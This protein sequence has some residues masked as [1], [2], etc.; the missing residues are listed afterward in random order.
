LKE[1]TYDFMAGGCHP[2]DDHVCGFR[3]CRSKRSVGHL[4]LGE[5]SELCL[6]RAHWIKL[7]AVFNAS[8]VSVGWLD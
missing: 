7:F 3:Q 2:M 8:G 6:C 1:Q 4:I 5:R